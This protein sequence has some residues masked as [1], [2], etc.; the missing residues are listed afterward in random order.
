MMTKTLKTAFRL[1]ILIPF[2]FQI[3]HSQTQLSGS[4]A[5]AAGKPLPAATVLLLNGTDSTLVKGQDQR[6]RTAVI[7]SKPSNPAIIA[8]V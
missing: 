1:C 8:S 4:V 2:S 3:A 6:D 7:R 5:D